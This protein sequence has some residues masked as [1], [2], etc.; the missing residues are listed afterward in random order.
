MFSRVDWIAA[1]AQPTRLPSLADNRRAASVFLPV[2]DQQKQEVYKMSQ[3][4]LSQIQMWALNWAPRGWMA[5]NGQL[6][7][8]AQYNALFALLGTNFGGDG[9]T[10]FGLP[11]FQ[12]RV[13]MG[14]G[15]GAGLSN[16]PFTQ[17][18]GAE[19]VTLG[20][21]NLP[22]HNHAPVVQASTGPGTSPTPSA[23]AYLGGLPM[24]SGQPIKGY[25]TTAG[26][27]VNLGGVSE[28]N[29]GSGAPVGIVQPYLA[30]GFTIA[31]EGLFPTRS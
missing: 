25:T 16:R 8:I 22:A 29:V 15:Q 17:A 9:R 11:N 2:G 6:L 12:G 23:G 10:N 30:I 28:S 19:L 7:P 4:Y 31:V 20:V 5:C 3:P 26:T 1:L 13:P 14:F 18:A 21:A 27:T 24:I